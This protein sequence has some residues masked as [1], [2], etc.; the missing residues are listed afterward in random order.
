VRLLAKI[1]FAGCTISGQGVV[2]G[3]HLVEKTCTY[4]RVFFVDS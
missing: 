2:D 1:D 4:K 3:V